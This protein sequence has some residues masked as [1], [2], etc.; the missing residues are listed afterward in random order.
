[1]GDDD[2]GFFHWF[3]QPS[4]CDLRRCLARRKNGREL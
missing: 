3:H 2:S 4:R 1:L